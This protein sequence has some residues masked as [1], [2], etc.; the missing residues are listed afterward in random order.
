MPPFF[1]LGVDAAPDLRGTFEYLYMKKSISK[2]ISIWR[3]AMN[4]EEKKRENI[5]V[6][7]LN[8]ERLGLLEAGHAPPQDLGQGC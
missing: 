5:E 7:H 1:I 3:K 4:E 6:Q 8:L 2:S